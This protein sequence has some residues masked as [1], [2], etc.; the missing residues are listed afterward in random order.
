ME[1]PRTLNLHAVLVLIAGL[2]AAAAVWAGMAL[3]GGGSGGNSVDSNPAPARGDA[4]LVQDSNKD[5]HG[6]RDCPFKDG[7]G[8]STGFD[9]STL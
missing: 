9:T 7:R 4:G 8:D 5:R 3:A 2:L 6:D 1:R